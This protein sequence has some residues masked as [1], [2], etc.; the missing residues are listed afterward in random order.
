MEGIAGVVYPDVFQINHLIVPLLETLKDRGSALSDSYSFKHIELGNVGSK[1]CSNEKKTITLSFD[2]VIY[3]PKNLHRELLRSG[4]PLVKTAPHDLVLAAYCQ[5][6]IEFLKHLDGDFALA[7]LDQEKGRIILARDRIGKKPLY[8]FH[9]NHHFIFSSQLK[10]ILATGIVPAAAALDA[11][12]SYLFFGY[13]P[14]DMTPIRSVNKLLPGHYLQFN[15]NGSKSIEPYWSYSSYFQKTVSDQKNPIINQLNHLMLESV[16][17][18]LPENRPVGCFLSGGLG[19]ASV[20]YYMHKVLNDCK[21]S[22]FSVSFAGE[23]DADMQAASEVAKKLDLLHY[24]EEIKPTDFLTDLVKIIWYLDEPLADPNIVATWHLAKLAA[25][26]THTVF[27]GMGSDEL[28]AGHNRYTTQEQ[29]FSTFAAVTQFSMQ[30]LRALLIPLLNVVYKKGAFS[31]LRQS[32]TNPWQFDYLRQNA[33]FSESELAK[34]APRLAELFDPE[35]FLHKFHHLSRIKSTVSSFLYFDI[36]T[37]LPDCF[38]LQYERLM[39]AHN[40]KWLTPFL[41]Q[42]LMEYVASLVEPESLAE[43]ETA[44]FLKAVI[45]PVFSTSF[46]QRPKKTRKTFLRNWLIDPEMRDI[47]LLLKRGTLV[48]TGLIS[49]RWL[50]RQIEQ[51]QTSPY[52]FKYLWSILVLEI[53]FRL[54]INRSI[55]S[56]P[57]N[58]SV[59]Q[60]L[61]EY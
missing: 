46:V 5:W 15:F 10:A 36:K 29:G 48:E 30:F 60:L 51:L 22:A 50:Q 7:F 4:F 43:N 2:G 45:K 8:W 17:A 13:I 35:V 47:F 16:K 14:Q 27:S 1:L 44:S 58:L 49:N 61:I 41:D 28:F 55:Q 34:A 24:C 9:D 40:L 33:L 12:A 6:G 42:H 52:A 3:N 32:R 53:W 19:S 18:R 59:K 39:A 25:T 57:P 11:L 31:L 23:N 54:F 21:F 37:R 38:I 20:A 26:K 56:T